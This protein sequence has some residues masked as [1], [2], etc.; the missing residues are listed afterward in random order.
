MFVRADQQLA[1]FAIQQ[2]DLV[3]T[4]DARRAARN[5]RIVVRL[6]LVL[7]VARRQPAAHVAADIYPDGVRVFAEHGTEDGRCRRSGSAGRRSGASR[8]AGHLH[9]R[10]AGLV[11]DPE[12]RAL[13]GDHVLTV[14]RPRG[15]HVVLALGRGDGAWL[16]AVGVRD[17]DVFGTVA[18]ADEDKFLAVRRERRLH[19]VGLAAGDP[20]RL[21]AA[22]RQRVE[23]AEQLEDDRLTIRR[24][25]ERQPGRLRR[26]ERQIAIGQQ[27]QALVLHRVGGRLVVLRLGLRERRVGHREGDG[28]KTEQAAG[29]SGHGTSRENGRA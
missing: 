8:D 17:P 24:Q 26:G 15:R 9:T 10:A 22:D 5:V 16:R 13:R 7:D 25:I 6:R 20:L 28:E 2:R 11:V 21:A 23:I 18:I 1:V 12:L 3:R 27:R 29:E 14:R 4:D 19:V